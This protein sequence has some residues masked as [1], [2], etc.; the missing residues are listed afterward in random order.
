MLRLFICLLL[1]LTSASVREKKA[2]IFIPAA[3][4]SWYIKY[5]PDP[6]VI[7]NQ[8]VTGWADITKPVKTFFRTDTGGTLNVSVIARVRSGSSVLKV[9]VDDSDGSEI[10]IENT[11]FDTISAGEYTIK[12]KGYHNISLKGVS[13][14]SAMIAEVK[15]F[16]ISGSAC[17]GKVTRV[18][19]DFY[20]GRR[21]PSVHLRY[22]VPAGIGDVEYFYNEITVPEGSDIIGSFFMANGFA[23]GYFGIQVNSPKQRRVLF[24]VWSPYQTDVPGE[25][26]PEYRIKVMDRG[27]TVFAREFGN[28]GSGGQS[29]LEFNWAA[30]TTYKFLL[31]AEPAQNA[32]TDYTAWFYTPETGK[33]NLIAT[34]RRPRTYSYL[35][36]LYS[37]LENFVPETGYIARSANYSNQWV[38]DRSGKWHELT[39]AKFTADATAMKDSR[40]DYAGGIGIDGFFLRNCGFFDDTTTMNR[41][42]VRT[43]SGYEPDINFRQL[44]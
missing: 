13:K 18:K 30:G 16:I 15:G 24:S 5:P 26:P 21:G 38:R 2:E 14:T 12:E 19:D 37:F 41:D 35:T 42:F 34:F 6:R 1:A 4:N 25:V 28:E 31:K 43:A 22:D 20:F 7:S 27:P 3:G 23:D 8:G 10:T 40:L 44:E 32:S 17:R 11:D 33:W 39:K 9:G 29:Y 36:R